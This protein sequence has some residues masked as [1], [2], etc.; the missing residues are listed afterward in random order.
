MRERRFSFGDAGLTTLKA[1]KT[2]YAKSMSK[3]HREA[4]LRVLRLF[5]SLRSSAPVLQEH[6]SLM[7]ELA[8]IEWRQERQRFLGLVVAGAIVSFCAMSFMAFSAAIILAALWGTPYRALAIG[9]VLVSYAA[10]SIAAWFKLRQF[11]Q[12]GIRSFGATREELTRDLSR[13]KQKSL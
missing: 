11:M 13:L 6:V 7:L 12:Q 9:V 8:C 10:G 3:D 5:R 2:R 4:P 1:W